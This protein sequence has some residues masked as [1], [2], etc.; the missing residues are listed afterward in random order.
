[1]SSLKKNFIYQ[2]LYQILV[3]LLPLISAPYIAR[4]LGV[5][6]SGIFSYTNVVANYFL[7]FGMLGIEQYGS[8]CIAKVR[9]NKEKL[10]QVFS[11]L[12]FVHIIVS[13]IVIIIY[14]IY[15]LLSEKYKIVFLLQSL[16]VISVLFD[17]NWFFFGIENFKITVIRNV[18]IKILSFISIF[19]FVRGQNGLYIY[20][21]IMTFS[22]LLSQIILWPTL[23]KYVSIKKVTFSEMKHHIK[24][25]IILFI[26]VIA[27]NLNRMIDKL[28]LGAF[29]K[30][31]DLGCYEYADRI[32]RVPLSIITA[33]GTIMLSRMS[34][35]VENEKENKEKIN[36]M[37]NVT[38][39]YLFIML[40][41]MAAGVSAIAPEFIKV[42]LGND[43]N[44]TII[45]LQILSISI[46]IVGWNNF[47]RTQILIPREMDKIYTKS[48][49]IG[50]MI[51]II[52]N[53]ILIP[54]FS[55]KG[56]ALATIISYSV[57]LILQTLGIKK[58]CN[59]KEIYKYGIYPFLVS[60]AMFLLVRV[61]A[62]HVNNVIVSLLLEM[63][64]G[65]TIYLIL[66]ALK[67]FFRK[68]YLSKI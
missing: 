29:D 16:Y 40:F 57:I 61:V 25:L 41:A 55:A 30:I 58:V 62:I 48:V 22:T 49:I 14:G 32:I 6:N 43:Y 3:I 52:A 67:L 46:P 5:E 1:M 64:I 37:I 21:F 65:A 51:N 44:G 20:T 33:F 35:L 7:V 39:F 18:I 27:A 17:I 9:N 15:C 45:L 42:Y 56:A 10:N 53:M 36:R 2:A 59:L 38:A 47:V 12:L 66:I 34:N 31:N 11:E 19:V 50:A 4:V 23:K 63:F 60:I 24:P 68:K 28:M 13:V 8:R 26:A 54:I